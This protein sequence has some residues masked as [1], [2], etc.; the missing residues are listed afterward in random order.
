MKHLI[1]IALC[2]CFN[3]AVAQSTF[4]LQSKT[5]GGQGT[6]KEEFNGFGCSGKNVSPEL[7][8]SNAPAGTQS[9]AITVYD[10]VAP[11]GSGWWHWVVYDIP[12]T[13]NGLVE[14]AG[15]IELNLAPKGSKQSLTSYGVPG[16][17]G[18]CPPQGHG[19][20]QYIITVY[21]LKT[22]TLGL[23]TTTNPETIGFYLWSNTLAK[24]SLVFY[25]KRD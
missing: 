22:P 25:Y 6:T 12:A 23:P 18:P 8:W 9:Y 5:L 13:A 11:T 16:F 15:K 14:N 24:A 21:A 1:V 10:P 3:A 4:T 2:F 19:I 17:G 7:S 20:H